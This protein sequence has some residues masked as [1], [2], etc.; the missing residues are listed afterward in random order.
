MGE[1]PTGR[2]LF[3][4]G[5]LMA[6]LLAGFASAEPAQLSL[7]VDQPP[8][9]QQPWYDASHPLVL[10]PS[11]VNTGEAITFDIN[12]SCMFVLNVYNATGVL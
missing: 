12:P 8:S 7:V 11:L 6:S 5:L 2:I 10:T 3:A 9:S 4:T 1:K